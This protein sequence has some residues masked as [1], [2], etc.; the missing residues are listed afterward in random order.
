MIHDLELTKTMSRRKRRRKAAEAPLSIAPL[1]ML[2]ACGGGGEG[3]PATGMPAPPSVSAQA[4]LAT[5]PVAATSVSGNLL[6]ND[7]VVSGPAAV[8][9]IA[10]S[11]SVTGSVGT[12]L[13]GALGQLTVQAD[14]SFAYAAGV[15]TNSFRAL[16]EGRTATDSFTYTPSIGGVAFAPQTLTVTV[17]GANDAPTAVADSFSVAAG[18]FLSINL[19][20]NDVD[21]DTG[22]TLSVTGFT[23]PNGAQGVVGAALRFGTGTLTLNANGRLDYAAD[24]AA[25]V[26]LAQGVVERTSFTYVI[27]DGSATSTSSFE[28]S[29]SGR[30]DAPSI[31]PDRFSVVAGNTLS[32][33]VTANDVDPDVGD[34][35]TIARYDSGSGDFGLGLVA[36]TPIAANNAF[37]GPVV[38]QADGTFTLTATGTSAQRLVAGETVQVFFTYSVTDAT[39]SRTLITVTITGVDDPTVAKNTRLAEAREGG[40]STAVTFLYFPF[41]GL[42]RRSAADPAFDPDDPVSLSRINDIA[43][44]SVV[45]TMTKR[46]D[47]GSLQFAG[48]RVNYIV[49]NADPDTVALAPGQVATEI[50]SY[51]VRNEGGL[52]APGASALLLQNV[53]GTAGPANPAAPTIT[54]VTQG[55]QVPD[56]ALTDAVDQMIVR[57]TL[58]NATLGGGADTLVFHLDTGTLSGVVDGGAGSDTLRVVDNVGITLT[59]TSLN[60]ATQLRNFE[61]IDLTGTGNTTLVV[62]P[63]DVLDASGALDRLLILGDPGDRV[64]IDGSWAF[65]G[66]QTVDAMAYRTYVSGGA[67][68]LVDPDLLVI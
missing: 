37:Y 6:A 66:V 35:I 13:Q 14:G 16:P 49:D 45:S 57:G 38:L 51:S 24:T 5:V 60:L 55:A 46:G 42:P 21:P 62:N 29:V 40:D 48:A 1:A 15:G 17:T 50:F 53:V 59:P 47:Y 9:A 68:L 27:S 39:P 2:A 11:S 44:P 10:N 65:T 33:N 19:L 32:A 36:G 18:G 20:A 67:T 61:A 23:L 4:D 30:N 7:A 52:G 28:V 31:A 58:T 64:D 25:A 43:V 12:A 63:R 54:V 34:R 41:E 22:A 3:G 56:F 26:A 8:T